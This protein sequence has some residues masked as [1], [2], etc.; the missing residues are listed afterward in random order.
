MSRTEFEPGELLIHRAYK[1]SSNRLSNDWQWVLED[2]EGVVLAWTWPLLRGSV[3]ALDDGC[4]YHCGGWG[5]SF[6]VVNQ[7]NGE[8]LLETR[9]AHESVKFRGH[10]LRFSITRLDGWRRWLPAGGKGDG[11]NAFNLELTITDGDVGVDTCR[12]QERHEQPVR[13]VTQLGPRCHL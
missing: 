9:S 13:L 2:G 6:K 4:R 7:F 8:P 11:D 10:D 5:R 1:R 3:I 12:V